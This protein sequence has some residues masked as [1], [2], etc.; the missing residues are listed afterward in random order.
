MT[1]VTI[2][3]DRERGTVSRNIFGHFAEHLGRCIYDGL[4]V[5]DGSSIPNIRGIRTDMAEALK[6]IRIPVLRWPGGCFAD[7]Y[8]WRDGVGPLDARPTMVNTHWGNVVEN[9][10]FGTHEFIDLCLQTGA[11][12]YICGNVG[13]GTVREMRDWVEY[14]TGAPESPM[15]ALRGANGRTEPWELPYFGVGNEN[16]GCG[17]AMRPEYYADEYRRFTGYVRKAGGADVYRIACGPN[18]DDYRWTEVLMDRAGRHM[19]GLSFHYYTIVP[20]GEGLSRSAVDFGRREWFELMKQAVG[21]ETVLTG[22]EKIM[23]RYDPERRIGLIVDEWGTWHEVEPGTNPR[24]LYQQNTVRDA[25]VAGLHLNVLSNH[26]GRVHM[27]NIA[28]TVNV[29]QS[30]ILSDGPRMLLTPTYHVFEM[31]AGHHDGRLIDTYLL[32]PPYEQDGTS[33]PAVTAAATKHSDGD[34]ERIHLTICNID[35]AEGHALQLSFQ[36]GGPAGRSVPT[37]KTARVLTGGAM[38]AHNTFESPQTVVPAAIDVRTESDG[39][40]RVDV[41]PM[42][43]V[44]AELQRAGFGGGKA[45]S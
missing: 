32:S 22:H 41:P 3:P 38:N 23:D 29:L 28:Q 6:A 44:A 18:R 39:M 30:M 9:N 25:V 19:E 2:D 37:V 15:G 27:A 24:F 17:G 12:P 42:S 14:V 43:V 40:F 34:G 1:T 5:G 8:H 33:L 11:A 35:P 36:P 10:H 20:R 7:D 21:F 26:C 16:W 31:Y 13:S 4:W 45:V